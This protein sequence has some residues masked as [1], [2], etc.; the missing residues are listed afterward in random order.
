MLIRGEVVVSAAV[1]TAPRGISDHEYPRSLA[2]HD[3]IQLRQKSHCEL[4]KV[5]AVR[6]RSGS[7][8]AQLKALSR[9]SLVPSRVVGSPVGAARTVFWRAR[10]PLG[11]RVGEIAAGYQL[12]D[13]VKVRCKN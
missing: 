2:E 3:P 7:K 4:R 12:T 6:S 10:P 8:T 5:T 9:S 11:A 13:V 1:A